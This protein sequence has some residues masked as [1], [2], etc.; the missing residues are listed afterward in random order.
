MLSALLR[1]GMPHNSLQVVEAGRSAV[2]RAQAGSSPP[3][4]VQGAFQRL[5]HGLCCTCTLVPVQPHRT[6]RQGKRG[7]QGHLYNRQQQRH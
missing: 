5:F 2:S 1:P 6:L 3:L 7:R 4:I